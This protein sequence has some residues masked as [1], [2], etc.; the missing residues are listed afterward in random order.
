MGYEFDNKYN[1][2]GSFFIL[3]RITKNAFPD[4]ITFVKLLFKSNNN[5]MFRNY[6][7]ID[8]LPQISK[9]I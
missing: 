1:I 2:F 7:L 3:I 6:R 5:I 8:L 4:K 9:N